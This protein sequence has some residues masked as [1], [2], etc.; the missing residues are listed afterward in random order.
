MW[1][2]WGR[3]PSRWC[4]SSA[5]CNLQR[6]AAAARLGDVGSRI[7][8]AVKALVKARAEPGLWLEEVPEPSFGINDVLIQVRKTGICGTDLHIHGWDAGAADDSRADGGGPRVRGRDRG[9]GLERERLPR[10]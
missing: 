6:S 5:A 2:G 3:E 4:G 8:E 7:A 1:V 9:G 10:G